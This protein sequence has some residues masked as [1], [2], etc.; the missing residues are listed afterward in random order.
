MGNSHLKSQVSNKVCFDKNQIMKNINCGCKTQNES[1]YSVLKFKTRKIII[2][3]GLFSVVANDP[4]FPPLQPRIFWHSALRPVFQTSQETKLESS[5]LKTKHQKIT[6]CCKTPF[7]SVYSNLSKS[8]TKLSFATVCEKKK[9]SRFVVDFWKRP[10]N[11]TANNGK[12]C[13]RTW[14]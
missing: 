10:D 2:Y 5:C 4:I 3:S 14:L 1:R 13:M 7:L 6:R 12:L 11:F 9:K 8:L